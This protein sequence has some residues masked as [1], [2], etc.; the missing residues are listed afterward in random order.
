VT[1]EDGA[2]SFWRFV[3]DWGDISVLGLVCTRLVVAEDAHFGRVW[4]FMEW[5]IEGSKLIFVDLWVRFFFD[6]EFGLTVSI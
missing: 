4:I 2:S 5:N 3:A 6:S 1:G